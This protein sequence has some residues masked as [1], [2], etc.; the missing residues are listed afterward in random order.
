MLGNYSIGNSVEFDYTA[1]STI[2]TLR[3]LGKAHHHHQ[4][5]PGDG[6]HGLRRE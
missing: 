4:L 6:Q 3:S 1:V 2:R 5:Q